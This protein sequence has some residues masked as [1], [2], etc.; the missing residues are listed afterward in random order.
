MNVGAGPHAM[1]AATVKL[2]TWFATIAFGGSSV[3]W[4]V[5]L[6]AKTVSVQVSPLAK[7]AVGSS[8]KLPG[9]PDAVAE[10]DPVVAQLIENQPS[11]TSTGSVNVIVR[12]AH[13]GT[14]VPLA[15]GNDEA[16]RGAES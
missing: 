12:F 2:K 6:A 13:D 11:V 16:T 5:T 7:F 3:S 10:W 4:S 9:P 1:S 15:E 8:V 14:P